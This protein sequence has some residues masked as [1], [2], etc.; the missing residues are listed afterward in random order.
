MLTPVG[1]AGGLLDHDTR[2]VRFGARDYA[3]ETGRWT[4]KDP[5]IF[6][7]G[8]TNLYGYVL[9]DPINWSDSSGTGPLTGLICGGLM[10]TSVLEAIKSLNE[11][12]SA[13]LSKVQADI[14]FA[15]NDVDECG[16]VRNQDVIDQ[17]EAKKKQIEAQYLMDLA[18]LRLFSTVGGGACTVLGGLPWLP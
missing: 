12:K 8:D 5:I 7:G 14:D 1:F 3:S 13:D 16:K 2:L 6:K 18:K 10:R 4:S 9:N 15:K 11:Q 17:L